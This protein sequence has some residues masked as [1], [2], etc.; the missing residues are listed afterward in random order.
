MYV[1]MFMYVYV[2]MYVP[3][4]KVEMI[5]GSKA[6]NN[7]PPHMLCRHA[8]LGGDEMG[9]PDMDGLVVLV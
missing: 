4:T 2:C 8:R 9:V 6:G 3:A 7:N 1:C 5:G